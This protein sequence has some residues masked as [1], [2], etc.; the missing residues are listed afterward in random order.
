[1]ILLFLLEVLILQ[2]LF[3]KPV[4]KERIWGGTTLHTE[5]GYEIPTDQ[6]GESWQFP[7]IQMDPL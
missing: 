2:P 4:F 1:M 5:F 3:L 6:T 7:R